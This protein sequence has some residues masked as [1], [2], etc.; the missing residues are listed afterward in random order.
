MDKR[1][2][3]LYNDDILNEAVCRFGSHAVCAV[4]LNGFENLIYE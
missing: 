3:A 4:T 2:R 1:S